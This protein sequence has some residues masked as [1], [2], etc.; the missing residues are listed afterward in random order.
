MWPGELLCK[1]WY[2][3]SFR[4]KSSDASG[5]LD[6]YKDRRSEK[7]FC[8][9]LW[10]QPGVATRDTGEDKRATF[11]RLSGARDRRHRAHGMQVPLGGTPGWSGGRRQ[12]RAMLWP[13][14]S[15]GVPRAQ[16]KQ[17]MTDWF[18]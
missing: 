13:W 7:V 5:N 17:L 4:E 1:K 2:G 16:S 14:P 6:L 18:E 10:G 11:I 8:H 12:A 15:L 9:R 3:K